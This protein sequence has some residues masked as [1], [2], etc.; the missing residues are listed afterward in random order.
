LSIAKRGETSSLRS[1]DS[2]FFIHVVGKVKLDSFPSAH[3]ELD[4]RQRWSSLALEERFS[5]GDSLPNKRYEKESVV[6]NPNN[7]IAEA[8]QDSVSSESVL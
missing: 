7:G 4:V 5:V 1:S 6:C 3:E 8:S 2:Q